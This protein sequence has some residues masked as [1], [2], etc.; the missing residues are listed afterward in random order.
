MATV[1]PACS[2]A[3]S[4]V[5]KVGTIF[6][7]GQLAARQV[8]LGSNALITELHGWFHNSPGNVYM[9]LYADAAGALTGG[10]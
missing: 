1:P 2:I 3:G 10:V 7:S 5:S 8:A 9:A 6:S 4:D